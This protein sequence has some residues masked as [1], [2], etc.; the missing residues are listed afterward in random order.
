VPQNV[1]YICVHPTE[2]ETPTVKIVDIEATGEL[3]QQVS[4]A[5]IAKARGEA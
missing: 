3:P 2:S 1:D 5:A 4:R